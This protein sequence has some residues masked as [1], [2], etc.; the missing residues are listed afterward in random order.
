MAA[1]VI[2]RSAAAVL[3]LQEIKKHCRIDAD[4]SDDDDLLLLMERAAVADA[5]NMVGGPLLAAP[6]RDTFD[7]WPALPWLHLGIAG[8][9]QVDAITVQ[10]AGQIVP[11]ALSD[12]HVEQ[13]GRLLCIKPRG[14]W[15]QCDAVPGAIR[16]DYQAGFGDGVDSLP[17]DLRQW[18]RF[19]V[20]TFYTYRE[21]FADGSLKSLPDAIVD[22]LISHY[23]PDRVSL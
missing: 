8:G 12:F 3:G 5:E 20:A 18:L 7:A 6:C 13:E 22:S 14:S 4:L 10:R 11:V 2:Q 15:P 17:A 23:K 1:V 9:R 21:Q 16:V 19:R